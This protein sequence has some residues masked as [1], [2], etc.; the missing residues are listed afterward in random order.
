MKATTFDKGKS[1]AIRVEATEFK[2][3]K[4]VDV[5]NYYRASGGDFKPTP[6]GLMIPIELADDVAAAIRKQASSVAAPDPIASY[7]FIKAESIK[8]LGKKILRRDED[9]LY[10]DRKHCLEANKRA[11]EGDAIV[12]CLTASELQIEDG[13]YILPK[14][15]EYKIVSLFDKRWVLQQ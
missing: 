13:K 12:K 3:V 10:E 1:G 11:N 5:R 9:R 14:D 2:G 7:F 4:Y 15:A 6:K 8:Y